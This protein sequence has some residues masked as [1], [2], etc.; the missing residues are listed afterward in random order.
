MGTVYTTHQ[1]LALLQNV[2]LEYIDSHTRT[3]RVW[4][5]LHHRMK[6]N[7]DLGLEWLYYG[8]FF[9]D[10]GPAPH[11]KANVKR[12]NKRLPYSKSNCYWR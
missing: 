12:K 7:P 10:M 9:S 5:G 3:Y 2:P 4:I 11:E 1:D 8:K 6:R